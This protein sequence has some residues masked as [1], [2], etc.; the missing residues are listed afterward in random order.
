MCAV[1]QAS[2]TEWELNLGFI[3]AVFGVQI[4][5]AATIHMAHM[6]LFVS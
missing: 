2:R 4:T 1:N 5:E 3:P 6:M